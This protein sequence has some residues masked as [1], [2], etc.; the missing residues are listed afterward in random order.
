MSLIK[1]SDIGCNS[2]MGTWIFLV[3]VGW[4]GPAL[5]TVHGEA[6]NRSPA[7]SRPQTEVRASENDAMFASPARSP[8]CLSN[9]I[10]MPESPVANFRRSEHAGAGSGAV[11]LGALC[12]THAH[13]QPRHRGPAEG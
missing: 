5:L 4:Q 6:P 7:F 1:L 13:S 10:A 8:G 12:E 9:Q 2:I 11:Q 3:A